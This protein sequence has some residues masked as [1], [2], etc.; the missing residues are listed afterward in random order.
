MS[1][2]AG[3]SLRR[4]H[5]RGR[6]PGDRC[7]ARA[8][9]RS[10]CWR[11]SGSNAG[12]TTRT[13]PARRSRRAFAGS[14]ASARVRR[15][16]L[17]RGAPQAR[18]ASTTS[19]SGCRTT[20]ADL[21]LAELEV[22]AGSPATRTGPTS[23]CSAARKVSD[24]L[25]VI[26]VPAA[27]GRQAAHRRRHVLHVP[28]RAGARGRCVAARGRPDRHLPGA[29]GAEPATGSCCPPTSS[30]PP[31]VTADAVTKI[32]ARRRDPG[33]GDG[34]RHRP[35]DGALVRRRARQRPDGLLER[36]DGR[37]RGR[38]VRRGHPGRGRRPSPRCTGTTV[39]GGGDSAAAVRALGLDEPAFTHISTGG[40]AS[41]EFLEGK[42]CPASPYWRPECR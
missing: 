10:R 21:V 20:P 11:T 40:G 7:R 26:A 28:G 35:G 22:L 39:V 23:W 25:G 29:A 9:V 27:Q 33:G 42:S 12:E 18:D 24:K 31:S 3:R 19:P 38:A 17:R 14:S 4:R 8:T 30:S 13:T 36:P 16:R 41:L 32:V 1:C 15:R 6:R 5:R 34:P 2:S 37:L